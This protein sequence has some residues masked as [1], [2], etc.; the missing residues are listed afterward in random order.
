MQVRGKA[1]FWKMQAIQYIWSQV[2]LGVGVRAGWLQ[3]MM[4]PSQGGPHTCQTQDLGLYPED[5][6][7][8]WE[9]IQQGTKW[10]DI[11]FRRF[12]WSLI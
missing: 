8:T 7:E 6:G 9:G 3:K 10:S 2:L 5:H 1:T 11:P 12:L 4:G